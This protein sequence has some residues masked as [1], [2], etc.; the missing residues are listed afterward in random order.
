MRAVGLITEYNPFHN[1]HL[2][3][4]RAS[5]E[6][7]GAEVAVAVMSGH[8][9][10]RGEPALLDKWRRAEMAL[11]CGVD[12]V[13]E[14]PF[15]F[16]CASAPHFARGA[17]Q[18]LEALGVDSLCFGSESGDLGAL[19]GCARLLEERGEQVAERTAALLRQGMHYAAA[20]SQVCAE[21]SDCDASTLPLHQPNNILGIEYLRALRSTDSAMQP[22]TISRL[23]A[24]YHDVVVAPGNIASASGIRKRLAAGEPVDDLLPTPAAEVMAGARAG[25]LYPDEDLLHRLLLAQIFRGRDYLQTLYQVESGIDARLT[26]AA[27]TS[28]DWQELVDAV[29]VRQF[30][31]TR[32]QRTLMYIL[33]DV[34]ADLMDGLLAS[35]PLYLRLLGS[36]PRGRAFLGAARKRRRL[37]MVTNLSRIYSQLKRTYGPHS[38]DYRLAMAMLELDL[39]ATRNYSLLMPGWSGVS[40]DRDFFEA[41][42]DI[43][44]SI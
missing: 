8:F 30:T 25:R 21:L 3:H 42:L 9:L 13:I 11:R 16:A 39:R 10:Q 43:E 44:P 7:S 1:G 32:I 34:R 5:R 40:R 26:D 4:L 37:P 29:K 2:H 24:G 38:E 6:T 36:S 17:V 41:P 14:L 18:C 35:G 19:Q 28:R 33:N 15:P 12:V 27:A 31:R 22:F 23:G 20:R